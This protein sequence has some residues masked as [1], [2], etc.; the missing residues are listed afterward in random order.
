MRFLAICCALILTYA[1]NSPSK[2]KTD[3]TEKVKEVVAKPKTIKPLIKPDSLLT[4]RDS[5]NTEQGVYIVEDFSKMKTLFSIDDDSVHVINF[6]ATW[7][8]PCVRELPHFEEVYD[9]FNEENKPVAFHYISLDKKKRYK[10]KLFKFLEPRPF[11]KDNYL[12][13]DKKTDEWMTFLD[14]KWMGSIPMTI[15]YRGDKQVIH[16]GSIKQ[17]DLY[18]KIN[19]FFKE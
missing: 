4:F 2:Q 9:D 17:K 7:C 11:M 10:K 18:K 12:L 19:N 1:C 3:S 16:K 8:G 6:W 5:L 14:P 15:I 13:L